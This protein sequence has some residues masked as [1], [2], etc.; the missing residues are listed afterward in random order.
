MRYNLNGIQVHYV[1][2]GLLL[3]SS[4]HVL[5]CKL[6][7]EL[8]KRERERENNSNKGDKSPQNIYTIVPESLIKENGQKNLTVNSR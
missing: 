1:K 7:L 3:N 4:S 6:H 2:L 5:D 8:A